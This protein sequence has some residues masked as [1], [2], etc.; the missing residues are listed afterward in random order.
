MLSPQIQSLAEKLKKHVVLGHTESSHLE[1]RIKV[2]Q[3]ASKA[4]TLYEKIRYL[5]DYKEEHTIRRSAIERIIKRKVMIESDRNV[6]LSLLEELVR[7]GYLPNDHVSESK[8][9]DRN[10]IF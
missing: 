3:L 4:G 1:A 10:R 7:G 5:V 2:N 8:A 6:G 9:T